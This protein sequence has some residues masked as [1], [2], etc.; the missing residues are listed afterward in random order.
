MGGYTNC[1]TGTTWNP[2]FCPDPVSCAKNCALEGVDYAKTYEITTSGGELTL[3]Y[4]APTGNVGSRTYLMEAVPPPKKHNYTR[5]A[6]KNC[7]NGHGG[8]EIDKNGTPNLSVSQCTERCDADSECS[9]VT[10]QPSTSTCWKRGACE[11]G[12]FAQMAGYDTYAKGASEGV[13]TAGDTVQ[14]Y[15]LFKLKNREFSFDVDVSK[16]PCGLNGALYFV[17]MD[18]DGGMARFPGNKAGAAYGTGYCD[19]QC[20]HDVK[21][22]NGEANTL[23]WDSGVGKYG[24]C[25]VEMDIWEANSISNAVT[26]HPCAVTGQTRCGDGKVPCGDGDDRYKGVCDKDGCDFNPWRVGNRTFFG[27]GADFAIDSTRVFTVATSFVTADGTDEGDLVEIRRYFVQD[28]NKFPLPGARLVDPDANSLTDD[29]CDKSKVAFNNTNDHRAKG[30]LK[31]MSDALDRGMVLV[32]SLWDDSA[33]HMLWLDSDDPT[34]QPDTA[35][36]VSRGSCPTTSGDPADVRSKSPRA[37]VKFSN[38]KMGPVA[39]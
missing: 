31:R 37:T 10:Y 12:A 25:C 38:I 34:D 19:A 39:A 20:P 26:S 35:P 21:F 18:A 36:G 16:L 5:Y 2:E 11:P 1:Y 27:P 13:P 22:I 14:K 17:A 15:K 32:M 8:T 9:C 30:G 28:G 6:G 23:D 33:A 29:F 3:G 24:S 4:V 7:Y